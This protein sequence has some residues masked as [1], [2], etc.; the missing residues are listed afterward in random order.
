MQITLGNWSLSAAYFSSTEVMAILQ[1]KQDFWTELNL[2]VIWPIRMR[3]DEPVASRCL[4]WNLEKPH[5]TQWCQKYRT[6][7]FIHDIFSSINVRPSKT[8]PNHIVSQN[9]QMNLMFKHEQPREL[10][11]YYLAHWGCVGVSVCMFVHARLFSVERLSRYWFL[12]RTSALHAQISST[13]CH[14]FDFL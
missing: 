10:Q 13:S 5:L 12:C 4:S 7:G 1:F 3:Q 14:P 11:L 2:L 9:R 6:A 8:N